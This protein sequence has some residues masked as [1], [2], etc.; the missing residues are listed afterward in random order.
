MKRKTEKQ[1]QKWQKK[2]ITD[3]QAQKTKKKV[4]YMEGGKLTMDKQSPIYDFQLK[5]PQTI[6][7]KII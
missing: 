7:M 2:K 3:H 1:K 4:P 6:Y 5:K